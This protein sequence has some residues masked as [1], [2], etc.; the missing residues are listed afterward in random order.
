VPVSYK[1]DD[2]AAALAAGGGKCVYQADQRKGRKLTETIDKVLD[3]R[4][5][6]ESTDCPLRVASRTS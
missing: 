6:G 2:A 5:K 1:S 3:K 4:R